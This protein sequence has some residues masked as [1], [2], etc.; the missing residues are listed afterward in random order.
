MPMAYPHRSIPLP[1]QE[2]GNEKMNKTTKPKRCEVCGR[3]ARL[4]ASA[5]AW[6]TLRYYCAKCR[7]IV[8][9]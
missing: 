9:R 6:G 2:K 8:G 3:K 7:R 4:T 1:T 5:T